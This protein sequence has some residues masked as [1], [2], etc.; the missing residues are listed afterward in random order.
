MAKCVCSIATPGNFLT[1]I[2]QNVYIQIA[3]YIYIYIYVQIARCICPCKMYLFK[4]QNLFVKRLPGVGQA[5]RVEMTGRGDF[6][7]QFVS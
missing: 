5:Q 1:N 7:T 6:L 2:F 4:F 3:K